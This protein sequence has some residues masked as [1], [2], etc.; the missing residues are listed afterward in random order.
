MRIGIDLRALL[1]PTKTGVG[2]YTEELVTNILASKTEHEFFLFYNS[3]HP[4]PHLTKYHQYPNTTLVATHWPNKVFNAATWGIERPRIDRIIESKTGKKIDLFFSPNLNLTALGLHTKHLLTI[5]DISFEFFPEFFSRKQRLWHYA[6]DPRSTARRATAIITPSEHTRRDVADYYDVSPERIHVVQPG[7]SADFKAQIPHLTPERLAAVRGHY[8]LPEKFVLFL[9][10]IEPRKNIDTLISGFE[11]Y[12]DRTKDVS[13][14]LVVAGA[15]GW[16]NGPLLKRLQ[17][18]HY[19]SNIH[20]LGYVA[21][22]DKAAL[23]RLAE[24]FVYPSFYEGFGFPIL[25]AMAVGTPVITAQ[26]ASLGE[27]GGDAV[28][29]VHPHHSIDIADGIERLRTIPILRTDLIARG[30]HQ[31][32]L[33]SYERMAADWFKLIE[34]I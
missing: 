11:E 4:V 15:P 26:R 2:E 31:V 12:L 21:P 9:G 24:M 14:H 28:Y 27:V 22:E 20:H 25:E 23:Y 33:F 29:Y 30:Y 5:H 8:H 32:A 16:N 13:L 17:T 7:L 18:T 34:H 6:I 3:F 10:T 1:N 19:H